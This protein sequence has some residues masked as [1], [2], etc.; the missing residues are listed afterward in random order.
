MRACLRLLAQV[1]EMY[2]WP[3]VAE[4]TAAVYDAA[5]AT[6]VAGDA[7]LPRLR[8]YASVGRVA[9]LVFCAIAVLLHWFWRFLEW[10]QPAAGIE[11]APDWPSVAEMLQW[12]EEEE[13]LG[14]TAAND[15]ST[16]APGEGLHQ[17]DG[18]PQHQL[19]AGK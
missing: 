2:N 19:D 10:Q 11:L 8:R 4:R 5:L 3:N 15:G 17:S 7:L 12:E 1:R 14:G 6:D 16:A 9:G 13:E 18:G